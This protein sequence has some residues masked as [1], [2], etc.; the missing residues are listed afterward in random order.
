MSL[1]KTVLRKLLE[2]RADPVLFVK[3]C[4]GAVP[5]TQQE[6]LLR[7]LTTEKRITVR[8]GHGTGKDACASWAIKW[9]AV[10]RPFAKVV[11]TAPTARQLSDILWSEISKWMRKSQLADEFQIQKDKIFMKEH[12]KEWWIRAVSASVSATKDEQAETLAGFHGDHLLIVVDEASGVPDPVYIPVEGAMTQEDNRI[13]LIGNMTKN[14]GYFYDTHFHPEI[15]KQWFKLHW[16]S[17]NSTNVKQG[18]CEYMATKYGRDSNVYRIRVLGEPPLADDRVFIPLAWA[19]QCIGLDINVPEDEPLYLGVDVAR[20]GDDK[21]IILPRQGNRIEVWSE[22]QG[23]NTIDLAAQVVMSYSDVGAFGAAIDEI[24]VGA[25][26]VDWLTKRN[27]SGLFG[28]NVSL[29]SSNIQRYHRLRDELWTMVRDK[30]M[31][32]QYSFPDFKRP[33]DPMSL[34]QELAN[35]LTQ[36]FYSFNQD[37]GYIVESKKD[38]K[39]RGVPSPNIADALCL[40]EYFNSIAHKLFVD[41]EKVK[42]KRKAMND[43]SRILPRTLPGTKSTAW[44]AT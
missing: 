25:G 44:M 21:S 27:M 40:T 6:E 22:F 43:R 19:E 35:E 17:E 38:M 37:G 7:A 12:S 11:C 20:Y 34:G 39:R 16:N 1:S 32:G 42:A 2:W 15:S 8:S 4:I 5:S 31:R 24:G 23:L 33:G 14:T 3:E 29:A 36:P 18:Y 10:T 28:V 30:C 26:V 9:F 13:L 41:P